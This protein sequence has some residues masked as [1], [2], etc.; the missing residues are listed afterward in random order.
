[1]EPFSSHTYARPL[2]FGPEMVDRG[3]S[4]VWLRQGHRRG[5]TKMGDVHQ[6]AC[7]GHFAGVVCVWYGTSFAI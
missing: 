1:M 4:R 5:N 2:I 7:C 3:P 6:G